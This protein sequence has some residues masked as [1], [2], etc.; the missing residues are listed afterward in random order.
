MM[1]KFLVTVMAAASVFALCTVTTS[2]K[3]QQVD[4]VVYHA[5][6][7]VAIPIERGVQPR[8]KYFSS[9]SAR[10]AQK[11]GLSTSTGTASV[12]PEYDNT[13]V[14]AV[15]RSKDDKS[16]DQ[17]KSWSKDGLNDSFIVLERQYYLTKG[18]DYRAV[19]TITV[20]TGI[21]T[22]VARCV[23]NTIYY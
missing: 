4:T 15:E 9:I 6:D 18:Y 10:I 7:G 17:V 20:D 2:G 19:S 5:I 22:E 1:K 21:H 3:T 11:S 16:W 14:V 12:E 13:L 8:F 23:S